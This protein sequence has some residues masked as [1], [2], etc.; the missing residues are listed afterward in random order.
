MKAFPDSTAAADDG[1]DEQMVMTAASVSALADT[2]PP[3]LQSYTGQA[4]PIGAGANIVFT[5]S[6]S[7][8]ANAGNITILDNTGTV[9]VQEAI[10]SPRIT[11][12]GN[13]VTL[14]PWEDLANAASYTIRLD[15]GIVKDAAGNLSALDWV[16]IATSLSTTPLNLVG[17]SNA[18]TL[19]GGLA[20]DTI[21]AGAGDDFAYGY[22][23]DDTLNGGDETGAFGGDHLYGG[24][25]NDTLNG[26]AGADFLDGGAGSDVLDGGTGDDTLRDDAGNNILRGGEGNDALH[27]LTMGTA[28][29]LD[30]G[31]GDDTLNG[32]DDDKFIGGTGN[33]T[34]NISMMLGGA[35]TTAAGG[36]GNDRFNVSHFGVVANSLT[37]SGGAGADT[38]DIGALADGALNFTI[39]DFTPGAG[40]DRIDLLDDIPATVS[41]NPFAGSTPFLRLVQSGS[42]TLLQADQSGTGSYATVL[43][44]AG[45]QPSQLTADN[46][47]G[48][49]NPNGSPVGVTIN[50]TAFDD[51][52]SGFRLDDTIEGGDGADTLEGGAGNDFLR[53]GTETAGD[54]AD[55]LFGGAGSDTLYGGAGDDT[56]DGGGLAADGSVDTGKDTLHGGTGNDTLIGSVD[57]TLYGGAGDDELRGGDYAGRYY[58]EDGNDVFNI[59]NF[60]SGSARTLQLDGGAGADVFNLFVTQGYGLSVRAT[61][62]TGSDLYVATRSGALPASCT[63]TDF[64]TADGD[65]IDFTG[66]LPPDPATNPFGASGYLRAEQVGANTVI[67]LDADGSAG[68][69][70]TFTPLFVLENVQLSTLG[71]ANFTG[72]LD[73]S[74]GQVG[75]TIGGTASGDTLVGGMLDDRLSGLD[76]SDVLDGGAGNDYLDGGDDSVAGTGDQISGSYG[77]DQLLGGMGADI[78]DGGDGDDTLLGGIGIDTLDGGAGNDTLDGGE[79]NDSLQ[80]AAGNNTLRGGGGDDTVS[81]TGT[82]TNRLEGGDG[83]DLLSGGFGSDTLVGGIGNDHL[84]VLGS[85]DQ[86]ARTVILD[87]GDGDDMM[88]L[89]QSGFAHSV[90][91]SGG[92]GADT[93]RF[94]GSFSGQLRVTDFVAGKG[95]DVID[96][97]GLFEGALGGSYEGGNPFGAAGFL[98]AVQ[99]DADTLLQFDQDGAAGDVYGFST[100]AVL[101]NV[102]AANLGADNF[103][104]GI[105][106]SGSSAGL[107]LFGTDDDDTLTGD[108]LDDQLFGALGN[109]ILQGAGGNDVLDGAVGLD[110][111]FGG[112]GSDMLLGGKDAD[113]LDGGA[114]DD[115]LDGGSGDDTLSDGEGSNVLDGGDGNDILAANG[116]GFNQLDGGAGDDL[117]QGGQGA[118]V[119]MGD[120]GNDRFE[121]IANNVS[122]GTVDD[123]TVDGGEGNDEFFAFIAP[124]RA[125]NLT[126][127]GG[128]G[129]DTYAMT[130]IGRP[131]AYTVTDFAAGAGGDRIDLT[132]ILG[133]GYS[134]PNPFG[135]AGPFRMLQR[136]ADAILQYDPDGANGSMLFQDMLVL[137]NVLANSLRADNFVGGYAPNTSS[138]GITRA[139]TAGADTLA[140]TLLDDTLS[141]LAG[142]D[143]LSGGDGA[144]RLDGGDGNDMLTGG[145]GNDTLIGGTGLDHAVFAGRLA[146]FTLQR[147]GDSVTAIDSRG[148][149]GTDALSGVERLL[150]DD[151]GFAYDVSGTG[152]QVYRL[153]QAAFN[154]IPD[155]GG[156]GFWMSVADKGAALTQ[157]SGEF[158][159]SAEFKSLYGA[160]T[161]NADLVALLYVNAL[162]REPDAAGLAYWTNVLDTG[163]ATREQVLFGFSESAENQEAVAPVIGNGFAYQPYFG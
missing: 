107:V 33:D 100:I 19:F 136:G 97:L 134:G 148:T 58:G 91:A 52:L 157:I 105:H 137:Q 104:G 158:M 142:N 51:T 108:L 43:R 15:A 22:A 162:H 27:A 114:G 141:G 101:A 146:D 156:V 53:G 26:N 129:V 145:A 113:M 7:V 61:G 82:G 127:T 154:R 37:M 160:S 36:D 94:V 11:I 75:Q 128:A 83:N 35:G 116:T 161:S 6:E 159:Q 126:V 143:T 92:A 93:Y 99:Q 152:G 115:H 73:P 31:A 122:A 67:S 47:V 23:G 76:G 3:A 72:W 34:I 41:G 74:G 2:S 10:T 68:T 66:M 88:E 102:N 48:G 30:G 1:R 150:F 147:S 85:F 16:S 131:V 149:L 25:G 81:S 24:D 49:I 77:N 64:S 103:T 18:D 21:S 57:S 135:E 90:T 111:L 40:G 106:P 118:A 125:I 96:V 38:Y 12:S 13:T 87:G 8:L 95:G 54:G 89:F 56:L 151:A 50:G 20:G 44:F 42:D 119:M 28:S 62:G 163:Q 130:V 144:D 60:A 86:T 63:I 139:G 29:E 153:Y 32:N 69:A 84:Q 55:V 121:I 78:L 79:G 80:D 120:L 155:L 17:T 14:N 59:L 70:S 138:I 117:L 140:G 132:D 65:R 133:A 71:A 123:V 9:V 110:Q 5:F 45:I 98:R 4:G 39:T 46:F 124:E 109:D 112:D